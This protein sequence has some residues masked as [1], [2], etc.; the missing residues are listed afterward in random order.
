MIINRPFPEFYNIY[1]SYRGFTPLEFYVAHKHIDNW[2]TPFPLRIGPLSGA[3]L[4][5]G[6]MNATCFKPPLRFRYDLGIT[7]WKINGWNLQPSPSSK[8]K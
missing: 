7:P 3:M 2:K 5:F 8:G 1:E 6:A 4:N